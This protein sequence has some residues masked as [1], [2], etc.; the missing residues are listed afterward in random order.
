MIDFFKRI[1]DSLEFYIFAGIFFIVI[2]YFVLSPRAIDGISMEP[3]LWDQSLILVYK[4]QYINSHPERGDIVVFKHSETDDYIK[5]VIGLPGETVLIQN[6]KIYI[7][8]TQLAETYIG[9]TVVTNPY[10]AIREGVPYKVPTGKYVMIGDN[11][12]NSTDS[13]EFGAVAEEYIEGRAVLVWFPPEDS[14]VLKRVD[15]GT[16][17]K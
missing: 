9:E 13:R 17:F 12:E 15:Y 11:R 5:R 1:L 10:A 6:G 16:N 3:T 14:K 4:L 7:N 2:W 8:G